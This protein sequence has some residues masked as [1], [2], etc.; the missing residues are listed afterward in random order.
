[1]KVAAPNDAFVMSCHIGGKRTTSGMVCATL[2]WRA[3][4]APDPDAG[5]PPALA[6]EADLASSDSQHAR[7]ERLALGIGQA[8]QEYAVIVS[9]VKALGQEGKSIKA[10]VDA[11][12]SCCSATYVAMFLFPPQPSA[13]DC[14]ISASFPPHESSGTRSETAWPRARPSSRTC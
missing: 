7:I 13:S 1:M 9:L 10:E 12:M 5:L 8:P 6:S 11:V 3:L 4:H 2:V 14:L